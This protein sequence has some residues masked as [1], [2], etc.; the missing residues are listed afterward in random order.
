VRFGLIGLLEVAGEDGDK[1]TIGRG[2]ETALLAIFLLHANE[3]VSTERLRDELFGEPSRAGAKNIQIYVSRL[4]RSLGE[5]RLT[6]TSAGYVLRVEPGELDIDRFEQ[7]AVEGRQALA[8]GDYSAGDDLLTRA[9]DLWRGKPLAEFEFEQFAQAE[10]RRLEELRAGVRADLIDVRLGLGQAVGVVAELE[11]LVEQNPLWERP[12]GQLMLAL[13]QSGRQAEALEV[14]RS[15]RARLAEELGIEPTPELQMLEREILNHDPRL[16][17]PELRSGPEVAS[18]ADRS[19]PT[20]PWRSRRFQHGLVVAGAVLLVA[21]AAAAAGVEISRG[22]GRIAIPVPDSVAA[23]NIRSGKLIA[24]APVRS[25]PS[26]VAVGAGGIWTANVDDDTVSRINPETNSPIQTITVGNAPSAVA[27][28]GGFVWVTN[29]LEGSVSKI[30][31]NLNGGSVVGAPITVGNGPSGIAYGDGGVWVANSTDRTVT[32][33]DPISGK[34]GTP[35]PVPDGADGIA[36]GDGAVWVTSE[37]DGS[38]SRIDPRSG[39]VD[40]PI[41]VSQ[42]ADAVAVGPGAV[43]VANSLAGTVSRVDPARSIVSGTVVGVGDEPSGIAVSPDGKTI[44]VS[45]ETS[46]TLSQIDPLRNI[47]V[48]TVATGNRPEGI[49]ISGNRM[50]VAVKTSQLVHRGGTLSILLSA[51]DSFDSIDPAVALAVPSWS[52]LILTNDGL[53]TFKRVGGSDG[54]RLVPDL[55]TT[56]PTPTNDGETYTFQ[57]RRGI[58]YSN[59]A[60]VEPA[61][62]RR[63]IER[64]VA[65]GTGYYFS[66]LRGYGRCLKTPKRCDLSEGIVTHT[67]SNTVTFHLTAPDPDFLQQLGQPAAYAVPANT[68]LKA[69]LPLPATGPYEISSYDANRGIRL[70]RNPRFHEW[71]GAAQPDGYPDQIVWRFNVPPSAQRRAVEQ[72][73]ADVANDTASSNEGNIPALATLTALRTRYAS[74]LHLDPLIAT[75]YVFLN[76]R[77][78]PFNNLKARQAVN[79]AV[80]RNRM[81]D[82]RGGPTLGQPTCQVLPPNINGYQRYCPYTT[83][84]NA[85]GSYT[86]PNLAEAQRLVAESGTRGQAV[87]VAGV[88]GVFQPHGGAYLVSVLDSLHYRAHFRNFPDRATYF[89][90]AKNS[91]QK[92]QA[93]I[94]V[95]VQDYPTAGDFLPPLLTC[96][97]FIPHSTN[98]ENLAEFCNHRIDAEIARARS[99]EVADPGAASRLWRA[100]DHDIV[101]Q[102]PWVFL[103]NPLQVTLVSRRVGNYQYNPQWG[104]LLDQLWVQ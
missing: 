71:Y 73:K 44:W 38:L 41:N 66:V 8:A 60:L 90:A 7:L 92:I 15:T 21:A 91:R 47:V 11:A 103:Q 24:A 42:G 10:I 84:P 26:A 70:V 77:V 30:D 53:V 1:I 96:N 51:G 63:G 94:S 69:R 65:G 19:I 79:Y 98:N 67:S 18:V 31:P 48:R 25:G 81:N 12:R 85:D 13:Y 22:G 27:V 40:P 99:L 61:D 20:V 3:P 32:R 93:G 57:V 37:S 75:L 36:F 89:A 35:I 83:R 4:R 102:A 6:T 101:R 76:T 29:S 34:P 74:Q 5:K 9:L 97:S 100:V 39:I 86:G 64:S 43:W 78:P 17:K 87:T 88:A 80:D 16:K 62:F 82:F 59:G 49:A 58:R 33:I 23:Y 2:K 54:T 14:Y 50:Y 28:G 55:A 72:G 45:S 46:G 52:T 95:W 56:I 104:V 68:P